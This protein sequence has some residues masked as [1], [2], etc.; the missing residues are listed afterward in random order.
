M[1]Y[2]PASAP[3]SEPQLIADH[4]ALDLINTVAQVDGHATDFWQTDEDVWLWLR[5]AGVADEEKPAAFKPLALRNAARALREV[6]R[7]LVA[8][9]QAGGKVDVSALNAFLTRGR[10]ELE[11]VADADKLRIVRRYERRTPEQWLMPLAESAA[12]LLA[13]GN[14]DLV[15]KCEH[16]DCTLY[17][18][19]RTKSH[20]R[21]WCSMAVCGNRHKVANF[22]RRREQ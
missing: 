8:Q 4:L 13:D 15:R 16:P 9:R 14:F 3:S 19:D 1:K 6:V 17:F 7:M 18:Y 12:Q 20:R 11:L 2:A 22:R 10:Y 5:R 21:R